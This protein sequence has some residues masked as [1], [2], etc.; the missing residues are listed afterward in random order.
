PRRVLFGGIDA[1]LDEGHAFDAVLDRRIDDLFSGR[2]ALA[3]CRT[4]RAGRF[5]IDVGEALEIT[6]RMARRH[7]AAA[8]CHSTRAGAVPGEQLAR[9]AERREP[10]MVRMLL[11][12]FQ[13]ALTAIDAQLQG[14]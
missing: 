13:P 14:I 5:G 1:G 4:D 9:L 7:T 10:E 6:F 12:P 11:V 8:A 3:P 2:S